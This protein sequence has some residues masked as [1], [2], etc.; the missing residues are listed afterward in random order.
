MSRETHVDEKILEA[1]HLM[2]DHFPESVTLVHKTK[3]IVAVNAA[4]KAAGREPGMFCIKQGRPEDHAIC[5][6]A[7][8]VAKHRAQ[9]VKASPSQDPDKSFVAFWLPVD[10]HPDF[11]VHFSIGYRVDYSQPPAE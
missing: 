10:G 6:A 9:W 2:Y 8:A 4:G 7:K 1:F 11:Y 5:R 3:Q